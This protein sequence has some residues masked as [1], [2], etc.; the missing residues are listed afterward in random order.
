MCYHK[1]YFNFHVRVNLNFR[2]KS[3]KNNIKL[4]N[5]SRFSIGDALTKQ[6]IKGAQDRYYLMKISLNL[7]FSQIRF[8]LKPS[9]KVYF[10]VI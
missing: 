1:K 9:N 3:G 10:L 4:T 7:T 5:L 8:M 2:I 6:N